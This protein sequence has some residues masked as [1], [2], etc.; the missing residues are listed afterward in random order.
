MP[1]VME[2]YLMTG[3][4]DY[5]LRVVVEDLRKYQSLVIDRLSTIPL[6]PTSAP[7]LP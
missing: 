5:L 4:S 6:S 1:A 7:A 3:E 2:C